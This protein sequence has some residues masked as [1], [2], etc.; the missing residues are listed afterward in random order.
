V[1]T[2]KRHDVQLLNSDLMIFNFFQNCKTCYYLCFASRQMQFWIS[3]CFQVIENVRF[4]DGEA[5]EMLSTHVTPQQP[6]DHSASCASFDVTTL[7]VQI[8]FSN[9]G[10]PSLAIRV[11]ALDHVNSGHLVCVPDVI[12]YVGFRSEHN[13]P[14]ML[15]ITP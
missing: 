10:T 3:S 2:K 9:R 13:L 14:A 15:K 12:L 4:D 8:E 7:H 1:A 6:R 5:L 11:S